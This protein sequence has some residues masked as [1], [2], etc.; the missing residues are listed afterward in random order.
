MDD[1]DFEFLEKVKR[2]NIGIVIVC[3]I[4]LLLTAL[5]VALL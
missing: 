2:Q 4:A 1:R 5:F 3:G